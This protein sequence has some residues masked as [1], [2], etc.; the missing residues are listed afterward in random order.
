MYS[1]VHTAIICGIDSMIISV[2]ADISNGMPMFSMVGFLSS[3]VKESKDRVR[4]ALKNTGFELPVKRI[5][6]N[7][8]PAN[9]R[10]SGSGFDLPV[11]VAVLSAM[12]RV[13]KELLKECMLVGELSLE[14]RISPVTG[15]LSMVLCA[16][17]AGM[18]RCIVPRDNEME[19]RLIPEMEI[20]GVSSLQEVIW[21]LNTGECIETEQQRSDSVKMQKLG[22][23][24]F[25]E[26]NGQ[27]LLRRACEVAISGMHNLLM[28][29]PPG[30]G[31]TMVAK[32]IPSILPPMTLEEQ[33]E[34]SKI[35]S[36][37]GLF[38]ERECLM[39]QR[40][41]R[42][43][44]HT[45]SEQGL[46]GGGK[47]P[48]PGE[49]SLAHSGVLFLDELT[50]FRKSTL[51]VL[52]QPMEDKEV[53][54]A[55]VNGTYRFPAN[56]VLVAAMNP[57]NCGYYPDMSKCR[58]SQAS[59]QRHMDKLSQPL[60]DRIDLCVEVSAVGYDDLAQT[61]MKNESSKQIRDRVIKIHEIQKERF[62]GTGIM[63]NSGIP[64]K[65]LSHFCPLGEKETRYM[66][67]MY[68]KMD[69]TARTYHKIVRVA[70]TIA[71][72]EGAENISR[73]HLQEAICYRGIDRRYWEN[74]L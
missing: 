11:A 15:V 59:I 36:V 22:V 35:Y 43:P 17:E 30:A 72:M 2:E 7:F 74:C 29:G 45:I 26:I 3:E 25:A 31:K 51:E 39:D 47:E 64:S 16:K 52:R 34:L 65:E 58:C 32:C 68:K 33:I 21:Y 18:R 60:L 1:F 5:T 14:G 13:K 70:R 67:E 41:Y 48:K 24:D 8:S 66:E 71:D 54:I 19:A 27:R 56:F 37:C 40:P 38:R 10:K 63:F 55:R 9:I 53:T 62:R 4:T 12:D 61:N 69:L 6:I 23:H 57:C 42:N 28:V 49:I 73:T 46:A 20:V 50:E 44:H